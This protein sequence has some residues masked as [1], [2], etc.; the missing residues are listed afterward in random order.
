MV[1]NYLRWFGHVQKRLWETLVWKVEHLT[2]SPV[3]RDKGR[4]K[5]MFLKVVDGDFLINNIF[6]SLRNDIAQWDHIIHIANPT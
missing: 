3:K 2:L 1:E 6:K 4:P 5:R